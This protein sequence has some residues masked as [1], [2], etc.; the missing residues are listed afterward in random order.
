MR[1][2]CATAQRLAQG[3]Y[4]ACSE[5]R[6]VKLEGRLPVNLLPAA[7]LHRWLRSAGHKVAG[8]RD[9]H[10]KG[11]HSIVRLVK[12]PSE[13]GMVPSRPLL[14]K[15]LPCAEAW[16][17]QRGHR[18][19]CCGN[20]RTAGRETSLRCRAMPEWTLRCPSLTASCA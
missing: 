5:V 18:E 3:T 19:Q 10:T 1:R 15:R 8:P 20:K 4:S 11:T 12:L 16:E 13:G 17:C 7:F 2:G 9:G 6:E 14:F